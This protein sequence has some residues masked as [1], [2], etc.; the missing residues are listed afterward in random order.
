MLGTVQIRRMNSAAIYVAVVCWFYFVHYKTWTS[1][2]LSL[3]QTQKQYSWL[4]NIHR[5][6]YYK[7]HMAYTSKLVS[8]FISSQ[9]LQHLH[10]DKRYDSV[11]R[12][13]VQTF[14]TGNEDHT[15]WWYSAEQRQVHV[16]LESTHNECATRILE[17]KYS[18]TLQILLDEINLCW[19]LVLHLAMKSESW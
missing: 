19:G 13:G 10:F 7:K 4:F 2:H 6:L 9:T 17:M 8:D 5:D 11:W 3:H 12:S 18:T 15:H 14:V 1:H 16:L